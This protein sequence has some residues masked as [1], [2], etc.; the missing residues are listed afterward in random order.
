MTFF[1]ILSFIAHKKHQFYKNS[2]FTSFKYMNETWKHI[3][4]NVAVSK[5]T[6][7][8]KETGLF[9]LKIEIAI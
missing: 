5:S 2:I 9:W 7:E 4:D 3:T 1:N 6:A 8:E